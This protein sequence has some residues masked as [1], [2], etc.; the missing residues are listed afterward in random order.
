DSYRLPEG[1]KR[2]AYDADSQ[3]YTFRDRLGQLYQGAPGEEYGMLKPVSAPL[4]PR[5]SVTITERRDPAL[6]TWSKR[7]AKTFDDILPP[8][9][10]TSAESGVP[11][12]SQ[13]VIVE[14]LLASEKLAQAAIPK[15]QGVVDLMRRHTYKT[16][17]RRTSSTDESRRLLED[18]KQSLEGNDDVKA[19]R[20]YRSR[21]E[22]QP[23]RNLRKKRYGGESR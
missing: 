18:E 8:D 16:S 12:Q 19:K 9:Y 6:R 22:A 23:S 7:P 1:M 2:I 3:R 5:R 4:P 21:S 14:G 11:S 20:L 17:V 15:V 10:I 13:N